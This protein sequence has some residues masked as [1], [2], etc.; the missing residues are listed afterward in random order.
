MDV[1]TSDYFNLMNIPVLAGRAFNSADATGK[2]PVVIVTAST[3][4]RYWPG[5]NPLGAHVR[6]SRESE[7][8]TVV[9]V[10]PDV[11]A[12]DLQNNVPTWI[13]GTFYVPYASNATLE[14]GVIPA[15][16]TIVMQANLD[17]AQIQDLLRRTTASLNAEVPVS[18]IKLMSSVVSDSVSAPASITFLFVAFAVLALVL[19]V[20]GIYGVLSFLVA[21]RTRE[22]GIRVALGAQ[23]NDILWLVMKDGLRF[24]GIGVS[25]GLISALALSRLLASQLYGVSPADPLTFAAVAAMMSFVTLLA[26]YVPTRRAM[27]VDPMVALRYE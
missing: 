4:K 16:M 3:A 9:G 5:G 17:E 19:G 20:I 26:C 14:G 22:V 7:W 13:D 6:F 21:R 18:E 10:V 15:E 2:A 8:R 11:R 25:A 1:I 12:Y 27:R 23:S 24:A